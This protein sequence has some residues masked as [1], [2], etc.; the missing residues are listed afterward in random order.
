MGADGAEKC[1][2]KYGTYISPEVVWP[3]TKGP[4]TRGGV[5]FQAKL[6]YVTRENTAVQVNPQTNDGSLG[7]GIPTLLYL[8]V[9]IEA[10]TMGVGGGGGGGG[11]K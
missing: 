4:F 7:P 5:W 6:S 8:A 3:V 10:A 1:F 2:A 11:G 9:L